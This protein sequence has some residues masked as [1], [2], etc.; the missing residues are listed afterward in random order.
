MYLLNKDTHSL[1]YLSE[2]KQITQPLLDLGIIHFK[3]TL[4]LAD[5]KRVTFCNDSDWLIH[6]YKQDFHLLGDF[7]TNPFA[8]EAGTYIWDH[9]PSTPFSPVARSAQDDYNI[10]HGL[11]IVRHHDDVVYCYDFATNNEN[12][13]INNFYIHFLDCLEQFILYFNDRAQ[14]LI[15]QAMQNPL[16]IKERPTVFNLKA[17]YPEFDK[18]SFLKNINIKHLYLKNSNELQYL[19]TRELQCFRLLNKG[20]SQKQVAQELKLSPRTVEHYL[21]QAKE[22]CGCSSL[23]ALQLMVNEH[24]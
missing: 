6:F 1:K 23:S 11:S 3:F 16:Q 15:R 10:S 19:T 9:L 13:A 17:L 4:F 22:R 14:A 7:D 2:I 18:E 5:G 20:F 12:L 8:I 24:I 21:R